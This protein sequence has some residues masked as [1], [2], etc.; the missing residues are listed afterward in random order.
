[1]NVRSLFVAHPQSPE[2]IQPSEGPFDH[3][4]PSPQSAAML[5]VALCKKRYDASFT[6]TL[7][8][9]LRVIA[10]V[11]QYAVRTT[12]RSSPLSLQAWEG[13]DQSERL[14]RV[15]TIGSTLWRKY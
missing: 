14:L 9:G 4:A 13:I 12:A 3:P 8:D 6:Q 15:V 7:T 2:L 1:V 11:A 5:R 10:T